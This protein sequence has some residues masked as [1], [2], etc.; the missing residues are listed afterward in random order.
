MVCCC[1][2]LGYFF[3]SLLRWA[4]V[5]WV[6]SCFLGVVFMFGDCSLV[7]LTSCLGLGYCCF[8]DE[9]GCRLFYALGLNCLLLLVSFG[10]IRGV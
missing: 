3:V 9:F 1:R 6:L 8:L 10:G 4:C 5:G 7:L 2:V